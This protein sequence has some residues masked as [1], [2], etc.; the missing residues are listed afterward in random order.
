[1]IT[2]EG[3]RL[4]KPF[5]LVLLKLVAVGNKRYLWHTSFGFCTKSF[6]LSLTPQGA[7]GWFAW[8]RYISLPSSALPLGLKGPFWIRTF[9]VISILPPRSPTH[10]LQP[11]VSQHTKGYEHA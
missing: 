8:Q 7:W 3:S 10:P 4:C 11:K 2:S 1:M 6:V 9:K 5:C